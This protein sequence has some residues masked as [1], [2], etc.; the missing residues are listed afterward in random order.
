M[1]NAESTGLSIFTVFTVSDTESTIGFTNAASDARLII[2]VPMI[3]V[4]MSPY[5]F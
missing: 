4:V 1:R 2:V 5:Q 3:T